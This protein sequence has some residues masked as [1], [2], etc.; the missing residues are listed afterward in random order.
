VTAPEIRQLRGP[1]RPQPVK[2]TP[3][4]HMVTTTVKHAAADRRAGA[5]SPEVLMKISLVAKRGNYLTVVP[6][7]KFLPDTHFHRV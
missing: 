6:A 3:A 1:D 7:G 2:T 5:Q 4:M